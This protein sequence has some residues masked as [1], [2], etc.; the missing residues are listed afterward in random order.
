MSH[1]NQ[2]FLWAVNQLVELVSWPD[3]KRR[4]D[5]RRFFK[6]RPFIT[7]SIKS[8]RIPIDRISMPHVLV[9]REERT[10]RDR[11]L[12]NDRWM[13]WQMWW[14][15]KRSY[16]FNRPKIVDVDESVWWCCHEEAH[17]FRDKDRVYL[18]LMVV[19]M[20]D[21]NPWVLSRWG[22]ELTV[23]LCVAPHNNFTWFRTWD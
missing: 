22:F 1:T 18:T 4:N 7:L 11:I 2:T 14:M 16:M 12:C 6:P 5:M 10:H 23:E 20:L 8:D 9:S 19:E 17:F 15:L 3:N 21:L 13:N